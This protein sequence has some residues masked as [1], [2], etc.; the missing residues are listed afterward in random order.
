AE[1]AANA[2]AQAMFNIRR[3]QGRLV[4]VEPALR[5]FI[6]IYPMLQAWRAAL[7]LLLVELGRLDEA[8]AEFETVAADELPRDAN[9][10]I[11][12]TLLAEVCGALG[13][14]A[15]RG[16]GARWGAGRGRRPVA[17]SGSRTRAATSWS[18]ARRPATA[19]PRA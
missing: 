1:N 13:D 15:S 2:Y 11:A 6:D 18:A 8:R 7:A 17:L 16:L 12:V 5:R 3:E 4:E 9:W 19:P 14:G 10:L